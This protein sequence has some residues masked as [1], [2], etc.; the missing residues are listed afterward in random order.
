[1]PV[2]N[3]IA[4]FHEEMTG[5]RRDFHQHPELAFEEVR[6]AAKVAEKL[7]EFG[8]DEV[9]TGVAKTGVIGVIKGAAPG[10]GIGLRADMDALP[11]FEE[12]G[13]PYASLTPGKMH[14]CGHD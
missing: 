7:R 3:R 14:A 5:W 1:M 11:I 9:I 2:L 12:S 6:T 4:D 10:P 13:V 8:V